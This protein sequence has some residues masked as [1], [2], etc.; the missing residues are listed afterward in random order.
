M[1]AAELAA[2]LEVK[3]EGSQHA[4]E[5]RVGPA[6]RSP[7]FGREPLEKAVVAQRLLQLG[8]QRADLLGQLG[9][10]PE[11]DRALA[12]RLAIGQLV[13]RAET[14]AVARSPGGDDTSL[15]GKDRAAVEDLGEDGVELVNRL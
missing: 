9:G 15:P 12:A 7:G 5:F 11:I 13:V 6:E 10:P 8:H 14:R 2:P 4:V 1:Q 3:A